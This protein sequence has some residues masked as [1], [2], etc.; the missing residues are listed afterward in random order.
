MDI[1]G[2]DF[3]NVLSM[4]ETRLGVVAMPIQ[5]PYGAE[6]TFKG[7]VDLVEMNIK[8]YY[9]DDGKNITVEEIPTD[10]REKAEE[11]RNKLIETLAD[12]DD[13]I[14]EKYLEGEEISKEQ[15]KKPFAK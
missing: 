10:I 15:L 4:M 14:M 11:Y 12:F 9:D 7:I 3:Y 1:L 13:D 5:L 6:E 2:A 8:M